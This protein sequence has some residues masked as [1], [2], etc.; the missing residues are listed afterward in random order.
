[1][2][3]EEIVKVQS[4]Q[5][6]QAVGSSSAPLLLASTGSVFF[7]ARFLIYTEFRDSLRDLF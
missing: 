1:M 5:D 2:R 7:A 4:T 6:V 3:D